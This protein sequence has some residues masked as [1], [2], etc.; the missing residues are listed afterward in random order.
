MTNETIQQALCAFFSKYQ[1]SIDDAASMMELVHEQ[2]L[3]A[4]RSTMQEL[5]TP[6]GG[7]APK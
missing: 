5:K 3:N 2:S 4:L 7:D 1:V 6:A